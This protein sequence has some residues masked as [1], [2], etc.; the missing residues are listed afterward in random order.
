MSGRTTRVLNISMPA[1]MYTEAD[2]LFK[3]RL[4]KEREYETKRY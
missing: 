3:K 4:G 1:E 2:T